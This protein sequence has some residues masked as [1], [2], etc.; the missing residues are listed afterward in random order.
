MN[1]VFGNN[2]WLNPFI[3]DRYGQNLHNL[4]NDWNDL[5]AASLLGI[6][7]L[8]GYKTLLSDNVGD[9]NEDIGKA[10]EE[11]SERQAEVYEAADVN[12]ADAKEYFNEGIDNILT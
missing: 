2:D 10:S 4:T 5:T 6:N 3:E 1:N 7:S 11:F 8:E 9:L 12:I